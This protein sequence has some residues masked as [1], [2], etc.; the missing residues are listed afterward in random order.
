MLA[1][2]S[3]NRGGVS[4]PLDA[5]A[6]LAVG[7]AVGYKLGQ[8][9]AHSTAARV[10]SN[11]VAARGGGA[12]GG[13]LVPIAARSKTLVAGAAVE[14]ASHKEATG[15]GR[16]LLDGIAGQA[17]AAAAGV[18]GKAVTALREV[19]AE[20]GHFGVRTGAELGADLIEGAPKVAG[21][22]LGAGKGV[23]VN[24][25]ALAKAPI[26]LGIIGAAAGAY[27]LSRM[28]SSNDHLKL[29]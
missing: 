2:T 10:I 11:G 13:L 12:V 28:W 23:A 26:V 21:G 29:G 1:V 24:R 16:L 8:G 6:G 17:G 22:V 9:I 18:P 14:A 4:V 3:G 7:G 25:T 20:A 19:G 27:A 5:A 15:F